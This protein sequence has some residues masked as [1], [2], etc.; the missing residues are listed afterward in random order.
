MVAYAGVLGCFSAGVFA[1]VGG[2]SFVFIEFFGLSP[3]IC[4]LVFAAGIVGVMLANM[5]NRRLIGRL[6]SD[7]L[8]LI[9]TVVRLIAGG[10][11]VGWG[12]HRLHHRHCDLCGDERLRGR[13]CGVWRIGQR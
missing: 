10:A 5:L 4:G 11:V 6:R 13:Q 9:G 7:H 3:D 12:R 1:Y 2:S 8:M